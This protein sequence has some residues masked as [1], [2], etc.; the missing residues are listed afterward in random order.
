MQVAS[1]V[2]SR[3]GHYR[4]GQFIHRYCEFIMS[5][6]NNPFNRGRS[7]RVRAGSR[8][9]SPRH[10]VG[11]AEEPAQKHCDSSQGGTTQSSFSCR[12]LTDHMQWADSIV[13][14]NYLTQ[15]YAIDPEYAT[16]IYD[17]VRYFMIASVLPTL[18]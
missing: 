15:M 14:K 10:D 16:S 12:L 4:H 9:L 8:A 18:T 6:D 1:N 7:L 5:T 3:R 17:L 2:M 11:A 13:Q